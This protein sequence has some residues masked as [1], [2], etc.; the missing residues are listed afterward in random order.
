MALLF[1]PGTP[2]KVLR[3]LPL[4][5]P[6]PLKTTNTDE[7]S[8]VTPASSSCPSIYLPLELNMGKG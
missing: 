6:Y 4:H 7:P 1:P 8:E 3:D 2:V 5:A